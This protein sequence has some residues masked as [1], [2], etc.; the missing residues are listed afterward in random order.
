[1][2]NLKPFPWQQQQWQRL[3][4]AHRGQQL[5]HAFLLSGLPG[6]GKHHFANAF[7]HG[8]LCR[9]PD[10]DGIACGQC[11]GCHL[12]RAGSHPDFL[13]VE[14][15]EK[16]KALKVDQVRALVTVLN[17]T[18]QIGQYHCVI[19]DP[20]DALNINAANALLKL[21]EEPPG[22][23]VFF[24][25]SHRP[26]RL[27][28][29][30]RSR[31]Q[32]L[33]FS[34]PPCGEAEQWLAARGVKTNG[35][36]LHRS[37]GAPLRAMALAEQGGD[38]WK[39]IEKALQGLVQGRLD[40]CEVADIL[41]AEDAVQVIDFLLDFV[42]EVATHPYMS[43]DS[44]HYAEKLMGKLGL[45]G[46]GLDVYR[47]HDKLTGYKAQLLSSANPNLNLLWENCLLDWQAWA[48]QSLKVAN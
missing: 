21:L 47:L 37:K 48:F 38:V 28:A 24:L 43:N 36:A 30:I 3:V 39:T 5:A 18:P 19:I 26:A 34:P 2:D 25:I 46:G 8:L 4:A 12:L 45:H 41:A 15:E 33:P 29:T 27:P 9:Q 42:H 14:L 10:R 1:M 31:C 22:A 23:T 13:A 35:T 20:A 6:L 32:Q 17:Q 44:E 11:K 16:A 40:V 7:V